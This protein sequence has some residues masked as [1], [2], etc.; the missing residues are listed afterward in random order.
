MPAIV[1]MVSAAG[2]IAGVLIVLLCRQFVS[3]VVVALELWMAAGLLHL[4]VDAS[5]AALGTAAAIVAMRTIG[6]SALRSAQRFARPG[7]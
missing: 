2:V 5:W 4:A 3:A 6:K 1:L 7:A